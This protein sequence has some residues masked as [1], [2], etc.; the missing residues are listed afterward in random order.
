[1]AKIKIQPS[2]FGSVKKALN[3]PGKTMAKK[4]MNIEPAI[5]RISGRFKN[6]NIKVNE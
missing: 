2:M 4:A 6:E 3:A 5:N 1:M